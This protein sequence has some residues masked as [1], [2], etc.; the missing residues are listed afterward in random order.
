MNTP[1]NPPAFPL[2]FYHRHDNGEVT[3]CDWSGMTMLDFFATHAPEA[4]DWW[5]NQQEKSRDCSTD[6]MARWNYVWASSMLRARA[7]Q[8]KE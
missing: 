6:D 3:C 8:P 7:Q 2:A 4:P 1:D 5:W